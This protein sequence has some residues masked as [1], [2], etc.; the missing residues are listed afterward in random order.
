[1][2]KFLL[3]NQI[4]ACLLWMSILLVG[5]KNFLFKLISERERENHQLVPNC[6]LP[7]WGLNPQPR[8]VP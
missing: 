3:V 8:Y 7:L 5:L 2:H 4:Q 1:M 6:M